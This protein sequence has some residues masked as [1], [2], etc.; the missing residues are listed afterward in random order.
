L[1]ATWQVS[2]VI[3]ILLGWENTLRNRVLVVDFKEQIMEVLHIDWEGR[4]TI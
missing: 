4:L 2:E 1:I 3:K